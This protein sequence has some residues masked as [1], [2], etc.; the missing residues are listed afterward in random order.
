[1]KR[2]T[3]ICISDLHAGALNSLVTPV[4]NSGR[5]EPGQRATETT[6]AFCAA[7]NALMVNLRDSADIPPPDLLLL[8]DALDLSLSPSNRSFAVL[9]GFLSEL[10]ETAHDVLSDQL[11]YLPGNH[12][13]S[14]WTTQ[15]NLNEHLLKSGE[16]AGFG[17]VTKAFQNANLAQR[18]RP[19]ENIL[20]AN[21]SHVTAKVF[22][23]NFG[24]SSDDGTRAVVFHHGHY[25]EAM[26]RLMS[27]VQDA[28][29]GQR[30]RVLTVDDLERE[31]AAWIDFGW[32]TL[33]ESGILGRDITNV[34]YDLLNGSAA[35]AVQ[36]RIAQFLA[37]RFLSLDLLPQ[38]PETVHAVQVLAKGLV[39]ATIGKISEL[40][41]FDYTQ[42]LSS[43]SVDG[44]T[45]YLNGAVRL[46]MLQE[47]GCA[48]GKT[49]SISQATT[50]IFGH[51][52][53]PFESA[54]VVPGFDLPVSICNT[55]GWVLDT[56]LTSTV[57]G[58]SMV[59]V[60]E[61]LNA[62][63][64]HLF[65]PP[66]LEYPAKSNDAGG[67]RVTSVGG[68]PTGNNPLA[69]RLE[70]GLVATQEYW[71]RLTECAAADYHLRQ[72]LILSGAHDPHPAAPR[73]D[74]R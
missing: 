25:I 27:D 2:I 69:E 22:N 68:D 40:E 64:V 16:P 60:D 7:L 65:S 9:G 15:V 8:G 49:D 51:T 63:A 73:K 59:F 18:I 12:D 14:L 46:Q 13:H 10:Y 35:V 72:D 38:S 54:L 55:G 19:L 1:M 52:H 31:N 44:L 28:M 58:A 37:A 33:G 17:M 71:T 50:F 20:A 42:H 26:Y 56:A 29:T 47:L 61:D 67:V 32:S 66:V 30:H 53:K 6:K 41:R 36:H 4:D 70:E 11:I 5:F 21:A 74:G 34:Y 3:Q 48:D 62:A 45:A 43:A 57:E 39:D 23:P 24:L